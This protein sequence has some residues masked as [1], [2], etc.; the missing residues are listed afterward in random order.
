MTDL[1]RV[2][3]SYSFNFIGVPSQVCEKRSQATRKQDCMLSCFHRDGAATYL[4]I[5]L[6]DTIINFAMK[7]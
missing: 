1:E 6:V 2:G 7:S 4:F 3:S 5:I